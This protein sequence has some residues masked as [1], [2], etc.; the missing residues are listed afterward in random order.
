[1]VQQQIDLKGEIEKSTIFVGDFNTSLSS[2]DRTNKQ[3]ISKV[4][5]SWNYQPT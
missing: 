5:D 4:I 3:E 1:M 2:V